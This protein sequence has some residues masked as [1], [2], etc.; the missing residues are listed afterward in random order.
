MKQLTSLSIGL[1]GL[2]I[3]SACERVDH[4]VVGKWKSTSEF[5]EMEFSDSIGWE[6]EFRPNGTFKLLSDDGMLI[7]SWRT[8]SFHILGDK[9]SMDYYRNGEAIVIAYRLE[10]VGE[11]LNLIGD[12][13]SVRLKRSDEPH[14]ELRALARM[15][16]SLAEAT[17]LLVSEL[18]DEDKR[19]LATR[20]RDDLIQFHM[21]WGMGIRNRFGLWSGNKSLLA[22]CGSRW[23][24]PDSA[25]GVIIESVWQTLRD[26]LDEEYLDELEKVHSVS[27]T[28]RLGA[29]DLAGLN[30]TNFAKAVNNAIKEAYPDINESE[31]V[32]F[33]VTGEVDW[34]KR[35]LELRIEEG[36]TLSLW[37]MLAPLNFKHSASINYEPGKITLVGPK[38][39]D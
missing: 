32:T 34:M 1:S 2:L 10:N 28:V 37:R 29:R 35:P 18:S 16:G 7:Q 33:E 24:H 17:E 14:E 6:I 12:D 22:S 39:E 31:R 27:D 5:K 21:G 9:L 15:P 36:E 11:D 23:M 20:K 25:S 3:L 8:G 4:A 38:L 13:W 19:F 26:E 30:F